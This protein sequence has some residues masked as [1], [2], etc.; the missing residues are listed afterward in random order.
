MGVF[1]EE[2]SRG[3][4]GDQSCFSSKDLFIYLYMHLFLEHLS[5]IP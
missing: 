2:G 4:D 1:G 3:S 5:L